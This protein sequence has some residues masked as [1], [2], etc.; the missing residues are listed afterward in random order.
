MG[1]QVVIN[2]HY[3]PQCVL[4]NFANDRGQV[5]EA[6]VNKNESISNKL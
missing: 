3:I 5:Y 1:E 4:A 6:L 2:Q